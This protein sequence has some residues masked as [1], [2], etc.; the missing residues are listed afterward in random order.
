MDITVKNRCTWHLRGIDSESE[1]WLEVPMDLMG[2]CDDQ[3]PEPE[4][5]FRR[6]KQIGVTF[7][8]LRFEGEAD[9]FLQAIE[10]HH[11]VRVRWHWE[12]SFKKWLDSDQ[13]PTCSVSIL[14]EDL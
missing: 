12:D 14:E 3:F 11:P 6:W 7:Y 13:W 2:F 4:L 8:Y 10:K 5:V 1:A 9:C